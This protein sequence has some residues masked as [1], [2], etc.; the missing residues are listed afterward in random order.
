MDASAIDRDNLRRVAGQHLWMHN[1]DWT[2]VADLGDP[3]V[4]VSGNGI[5]V[6]DIDGQIWMDVNDGYFSVNIGHGRTE[7]ADAAYKQMKSLAYSPQSTTTPATNMLAEKLADM[8]PG[9]LSHVFPVSGGSEANGTAIEIARA[10]HRRRHE[11]GRYKVIGCEGSYHGAT[12]DLLWLG[13]LTEQLTADYESAPSGVLRAPLPNP[14][15]CELGG[16]SPSE[17]AELCADAVEDLILSHGPET[18]AAVMAEPVVMPQGAVVP[19][20]PY[21]PMMREIC[22]RYGILLIADEIVCGFGRTGK[23]FGV[24]HWGIVPDIMTMA[25]GIV[26]SYLPLG[27]AIAT[28]EVAQEFAGG[29]N[30]SPHLFTFAG[31]PVAAASALKNIEI[32]E[33]EGMVQVAADL[34]AYFKEQ[35]DGFVGDHPIVGDVRGLGLLLAI[36]LVKNRETKEQFLPEDKVE[37]RL[38]EKFRSHGLL[39]RTGNHVVNIAPPLCVTRDDIDEIVHAL[40]LSLWELEGELGILSIA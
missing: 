37:S 27:A 5:R 17:C 35:L 10:Y 11:P 40:D 6:T 38:N 31:Y 14:Y 15:R 26:S 8:T 22:D 34:G 29:G 28:D 2:Q 33:K 16:Q 36:E 32:I 7:I 25:E 18:I 19:G 13:S 23:M 24:Q 3:P 1:N 12:T 39:L 9:T 21:W 20:D 30:Y 4:F